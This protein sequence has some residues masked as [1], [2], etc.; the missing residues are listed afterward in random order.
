MSGATRWVSEP[1]PRPL[2]L[3]P[4]VA[5]VE[6]RNQDGKSYN[7]D[8]LYVVDDDVLFCYDLQSG[9]IIWRYELPF[10]ASSGPL[11]VG[12]GGDLRVYIGDWQGRVRVVTLQ[13]DG[14]FPY[15][16]WQ[17]NVQS[18][19]SASPMQRESLVYIGDHKGVMHCFA[20]DRDE[21]WSF[22][23][24]GLI[25]GSAVA[26]DRVLYFG[27]TDN[28]IFA[29][30]RLTGEKYGQLNLNGPVN[31]A[32][33]F[34]N[35]ENTRLY[36]WVDSKEHTVAGL[37]ALRAI[38][39]T[40]SFAD[41]TS[42]KPHPPLEIVRMAEDW[43]FP[44]VTRVVGSTPQHLFATYRDSTVILAIRRDTGSL[45]WAWD[46]AEERGE[47]HSSVG[48]TSYQDPTD[49]N[50]S[51]YTYDASGKVIVYRFFGFVPGSSDAVALQMAKD[52]A[53]APG[54]AAPAAPAA[55]AAGDAAAPAAPAAGDA[56]A[57][58]APAAPADGSTPAAPAAP[59]DSSK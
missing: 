48:M 52:K 18:D 10:S 41:N 8:R 17:W 33:F 5:R 32:P 9:Q 44:G 46:C 25:N 40:I 15:E 50:R 20:L 26:R 35:G 49:L 30:N 51:I 57:P 19:F 2:K 3:E 14:Q 39:D 54:A 34:F 59:A 42:E 13:P 24:G 27:N 55:P 58:A 28:V 23:A 6:L 31:R 29:I 7:D 1:L 37:Y 4:Y 45:D 53:A 12:S 11:A 43:H 21:K 22:D 47:K 36:A 56:S 38:P 16:A